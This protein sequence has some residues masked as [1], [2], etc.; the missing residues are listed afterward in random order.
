[1]PDVLQYQDQL[2]EIDQLTA[3]IHALADALE[4]KG[5]YPSGGAEVAEAI[6]TAMA[7]EKTV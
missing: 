7:T 1:M 5:F 3:R 2:D 4:V 6:Q